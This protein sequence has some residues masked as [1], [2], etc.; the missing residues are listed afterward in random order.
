MKFVKKLICLTLVCI[1]LLTPTAAF[2]KFNQSC[3]YTH[4]VDVSYMC[5]GSP[6]IDGVANA[7][8]GWSN[9]VSMEK[10][11]LIPMT[12]AI[13]VSIPAGEFSFAWDDD[14]L[15]FYTEVFD[16]DF[17][18][19][20]GIN[21][22]IIFDEAKNIN[23]IPDNNPGWNGDVVALELDPLYLLVNDAGL[24]RQDMSAWLCFGLF[25]D[26]HVGA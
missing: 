11:N 19:S 15:Y 7:D 9:I 4:P 25:E 26:G 17:Q 1:M 23:D 21:E 20:N 24:T 10:E 5:Y 2:A 6:T 14:N 3:E 22:D 16:S 18:Y 12:S 8:E 13:P